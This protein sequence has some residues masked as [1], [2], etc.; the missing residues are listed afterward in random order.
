LIK[1]IIVLSLVIVLSGVIFELQPYSVYAQQS[2]STV[3]LRIYSNHSWQGVIGSVGNQNSINGYG[4]SYRD[5]E[6]TAG[7]SYSISVQLPSSADF[8]KYVVIN[9]V[10]KN[11]VEKIA[12]AQGPNAIASFSGQCGVWKPSPSSN[13]LISIQTDKSSYTYGSTIHMD[14]ILIHSNSPNFVKP[15][16]TFKVVSSAD[17]SVLFEKTEAGACCSESVDIRGIDWK[18]NSPYWV[19][20]I[21]GDPNYYW[22]VYTPITVSWQDTPMINPGCGSSITPI[23]DCNNQISTTSSGNEASTSQTKIPVWIK[24]TFKQYIDGNISED[25]LLNALQFLIQQGIIKVNR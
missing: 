6:C 20:F 17:G 12:S 5:I 22:T 7:D 4:D 10:D 14:A 23:I 3:S 21:W 8:S 25:E 18:K 15:T 9:I 13:G 19:E 24:N 1:I 2:S 11:G 16:G